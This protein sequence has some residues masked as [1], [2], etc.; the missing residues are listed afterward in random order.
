MPSKKTKKAKSK[1]SGPKKKAGKTFKSDKFKKLIDNISDVLL[2]L[3]SD[4]T[5]T[6]VS[7]QVKDTYG[8]EPEEL[9]GKSVFELIHP[10][11]L[12]A[13]LEMM[14]VTIREGEAFDFEIRSRHKDGGYISAL[15]SAKVVGAGDNVKIVGLM[16]DITERKCIE[17]E[18]K[19]KTELLDAIFNNT[20]EGIFVLDE[21]FRYI[22]INPASG[23]I[24]GHEPEQWIGKKAGTYRHPE[25]AK[26]SGEAIMKALNGEEALCELRIKGSD[27]KYRNLEIKYSVMMLR[28]KVHFLG[29]VNDITEKKIMLDELKE[30]ESRYRALAES[31]QDYIYLIDKEYR[32]VYVNEAGARLFRSVPNK[33]VGKK[34]KQIFSPDVYKGQSKNIKKVL[35]T[36]EEIYVERQYP[37][38][39]KT[40]WLSARLAPVHDA[41]GNVSR[42]MGIS[43]DIT[44]R[45]EA[46]LAL[47]DS[48]EKFRMI[49]ESSP[50]AISVSD[51][52]GKTIETNQRAVD[53]FGFK[54]KKD[55]LGR[56]AFDFIAEKDQPEAI[57]NIEKTLKTGAVRNI[58]YTLVCKDGSEFQGELSSNV[59]RN[60]EGKPTAFVAL[61]QDITERKEMEKEI[62]SSEAKYSALV[63]SSKDAIIIIQNGIVEFANSAAVELTGFDSKEI[64]K[65][66]F[67]DF[68]G[69]EY[70]DMVMKRYTDRLAGKDV[71]QIYEIEIMTKDGLAVPIEV[72]NSIVE[73]DGN[74][75]ILTIIRNLTE[76]RAIEEKWRSIAES[77]QDIIL[78]LDLK[79]NITF[80]NRTVSGLSPEE[81]VG[82]NQ[83]DFILPEFHENVKK[84]IKNVI[85]TG[86]PGNYS[87]R[88]AGPDEKVSWYDTQVGPLWTGKKVS[89]VI[90][91]TRDVTDR[92]RAEDELKDSEEKYRSLFEFSPESITLIDQEGGIVDCN[93]A[94]ARIAGIKKEDLIGQPFM[95]LGTIL[96]EDIEKFQK[97]FGQILK[98]GEIDSVELKLRNADGSYRWIE[99]F[100][101]P[102]KKKKEIYAI[103]VITRDIT[104][105]K[106]A[107]M[108]MKKQLLKFDLE[109][110]N[111]YI[112]K[113]TK[114]DQSIEIFNELSEVGYEGHI[115]SRMH[116]KHYKNKIKHNHE[117]L[118]IS[119]RASSGAL[120]PK[121]K[122]I[123]NFMEDLPRGQ[124]VLIEG[125][126][127]LISRD[128][129]KQSIALIQSLR[130]IAYMRDHFFILSID[131][132]TL[133]EKYLQLV[134]KETMEV[135]SQTTLLG[136]I[137][138]KLLEILRF[139]NKENLVGVNPSYSDVEIECD[140]SK[141]TVRKRI[142]ELQKLGCVKVEEKGRNKYLSITEKGKTYM[143]L[144]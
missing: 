109:E 37:L 101:K 115:I 15:G 124:V 54:N 3:D 122:D 11:D 64:V 99:S 96:D 10:D 35:E 72:N 73:Y 19:E 7:Q 86:K 43:R 90:L 78:M 127:Y 89:G 51:L 29:V 30:S 16:K 23:R 113:E 67:L 138:D 58:E 125:L 93:E 6:F 20:S 105:R 142:G 135:A 88:G 119:D 49:M 61:I 17:E 95:A 41:E 8:F 38:P 28:D 121:R 117:F 60:A 92:R 33:L 126:D 34:I 76:R 112:V 98:G 97:I 82:K 131:P 44:K 32:L 71:P 139:V 63:E 116:E 31:A 107:E 79:G 83:Y 120:A 108:E 134:E 84:V 1:K 56:S 91:F 21:D 65:K 45:K 102:L 130:E 14:D 39:G 129:F 133:D 59:I 100:P 12:E 55:A 36:G 50:H 48:E 123:E 62:K 70:M 75:A 77:A 104:E 2:E 4:G 13:S 52:T 81:V 42:V 46:E 110:G 24:V 26:K 144:K 128:G 87:L 141:P 18:L 57:K 132:S 22:Y 9:V 140:V 53:L 68:I 40:V 85:K 106:R 137:S 94:T 143:V 27:G 25:D 69:P 47:K 114:P 136:K 118:W 111:I 74:E 66:E 103:L 5:I 80:I